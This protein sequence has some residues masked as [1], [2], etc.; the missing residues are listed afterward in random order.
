MTRLY[1]FLALASFTLLA[2][3]GSETPDSL[4]VADVDEVVST[5]EAEDVVVTED[6]DL[7]EIATADLSEAP[8][9]VETTI[10][11]APTTTIAA[12]TT[13]STTVAPTPTT[14]TP[15][16]TPV[17]G[18]PQSCSGA[19]YEIDIPD[20]WTHDDCTR[21]TSGAFPG[22]NADI[23]FRPEIDIA[24][25]SSETFADALYRIN[26]TELVLSQESAIAN[27]GFASQLFVLRDEWYDVGERTVAVI[28]LGDAVLF[29]SANEL[30][31][32]QGPLTGGD[33]RSHYRNETLPRFEEVLLSLSVDAGPALCEAPSIDDAVV[34][35]GGLVDLD[36]DGAAETVSVFD[37]PNG[38]RYLLIE[39]LYAGDPIWGAVE[40]NFAG[41][42]LLGWSDWNRD[43]I[44]E[45]FVSSD[46]GASG[47]RDGIYTINGCV[48]VP[49]VDQ[50]G[51]A[52]SLWNRAS[53]LSANSYRCVRNDRD[54][55]TSFETLVTTIDGSDGTSMSDV[56]V[57][58]YNAGVL[59]A[60]A[61]PVNSGAAF[62]DY[63]ACATRI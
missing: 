38:G 60:G 45:F 26:T 11:V 47:V 43:G 17:D 27:G 5:P 37:D 9:P 62:N 28:D 7:V 58:T 54:V 52:A 35:T 12:P 50:D 3:C 15:P 59:T 46:G 36:R 18:G 14:P 8:V 41:Q 56:T 34:V 48:I 20:G 49:V 23:E 63:E 39:G 51:N 32:I 30:T 40:T 13:S 22:P 24:F 29:I 33:F 55:L 19:R 1:R 16:T 42:T 44:H 25:T 2:A 10:P 21:L 61:P 6:V 4:A 31:D 53:G 57:Y